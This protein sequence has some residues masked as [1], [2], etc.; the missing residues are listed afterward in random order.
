MN[1]FTFGGYYEKVS[2]S[3]TCFGHACGFLV[4]CSDTPENGDDSKN[5]LDSDNRLLPKLKK[6][7]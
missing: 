7:C 1:I 6:K 3:D 2:I 5:E 4:S